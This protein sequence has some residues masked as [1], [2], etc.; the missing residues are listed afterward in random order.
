ML[1]NSLLWSKYLSQKALGSQTV[2]NIECRLTDCTGA[3]E[4]LMGQSSDY[5]GAI[6][7]YNVEVKWQ[8][9]GSQISILEQVITVAVITVLTSTSQNDCS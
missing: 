1:I 9:Q 7:D 8:Y 5:V 6:I 3:A 2:C 4:R